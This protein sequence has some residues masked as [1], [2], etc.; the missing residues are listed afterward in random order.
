[1]GALSP[2]LRDTA[3]YGRD[4]GAGVDFC[5]PLRA[6]VNG[7]PLLPGRQLLPFGDTS[8]AQARFAPSSTRS[9][10]TAV[11]G[12]RRAQISQRRPPS[13][14]HAHSGGN[15]SAAL[16]R[17]GFTFSGQAG[18][19]WSLHVLGSMKS[20]PQSS[21]DRYRLAAPGPLMDRLPLTGC[22][23]S[24]DGRAAAGPLID[25]RPLVH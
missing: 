24:T 19:A 18:L 2:T 21:V 5:T 10:R 7:I 4:G 11:A 17:L 23:L 12:C 13:R 15:R 8:S 20:C 14:T 25:L 16:A 22:R 9:A 6:Q 3:D 1:M